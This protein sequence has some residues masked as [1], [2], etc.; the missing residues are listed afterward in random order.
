MNI[1]QAISGFFKSIFNR[2]AQLQSPKE[3]NNRIG[4]LK[5]NEKSTLQ[6]SV[7]FNPNQSYTD[8]L[9]ELINEVHSDPNAFKALSSSDR[10]KLLVGAVLEEKGASEELMKLFNNTSLISCD[11]NDFDSQLNENFTSFVVPES[12]YEETLEGVQNRIDFLREQIVISLNGNSYIMNAKFIESQPFTAPINRPKVSFE[13]TINVDPNGETI[14]SSHQRVENTPTGELINI[15]RQLSGKNGKDEKLIEKVTGHEKNSLNHYYEIEGNGDMATVLIAQSE[16]EKTLVYEQK[17]PKS[18]LDT[19][20]GLG[21]FA[22]NDNA[23]RLFEG[24]ISVEQLNEE[25]NKKGLG[26]DSQNGIEPND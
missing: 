8:R 17:V 3:N 2:T 19:K 7:K 18:F 4:G 25:L 5:P 1:I 14:F 16:H 22:Q 23:R 20:H 24:Q 10:K 21:W 11:P 6:E 9:N 13:Q 15:F 12:F 26:I